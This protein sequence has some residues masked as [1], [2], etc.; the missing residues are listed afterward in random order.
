MVKTLISV[1]TNQYEIVT[2]R[3][4]VID[5]LTGLTLFEAELALTRAINL[6]YNAY[7]QEVPTPLQI[8]QS[9][10][11]LEDEIKE[12]VHIGF[13]QPKFYKPSVWKKAKA[14]MEQLLVPASLV[15]PY[16]YGRGKGKF[17]TDYDIDYV[18]EQAVNLI[19]GNS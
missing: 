10:G 11:L 7:L 18:K 3:G 15:F 8:W 19:L 6:G 13:C 14:L 4:K 2:A 5:D 1:P 17:S 12:L 9:K 16:D